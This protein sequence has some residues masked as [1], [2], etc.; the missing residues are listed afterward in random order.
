MHGGAD[1]IIPIAM[2]KKLFDE[3]QS[4]KYGYFPQFDR[5]MM[6]YN[7]ELKLELQKFVKTLN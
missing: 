2:G 5:H 4:K 7:S 3:V 6:T 1:I